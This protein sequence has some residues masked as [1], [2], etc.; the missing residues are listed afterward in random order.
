[1]FTGLFRSALTICFCL[2]FNAPTGQFHQ[3]LDSLTA[4]HVDWEG[5]TAWMQFSANGLRS[6]AHAAGSLEWRRESRA[7]LRGN[8]SLQMHME[9]N[10]SSSNFCSFRF[11]ETVPSFYT[12]QLSGSSG[13]D[14][15]LILNTPEKDVSASFS[16]TQYPRK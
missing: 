8:W 2:I 11:I 9:F 16:D 13:D 5:D 6:A 14:L 7:E 1:M 15:S 3:L 10:P 12:I 4:P